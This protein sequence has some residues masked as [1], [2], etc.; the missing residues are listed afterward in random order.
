MSKRIVFHTGACVSGAHGAYTCRLCYTVFLQYS[1]GSLTC[2]RGHFPNVMVSHFCMCTAIL[3]LSSPCLTACVCMLNE[4]AV[5][6]ALCY[7]HASPIYTPGQNCW[8]PAVH[9]DKRF[10]LLPCYVHILLLIH[11]EAGIGKV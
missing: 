4:L 5:Q 10:L 9:V 2:T 11:N 3:F 6:V 1:Q 8:G 7:I